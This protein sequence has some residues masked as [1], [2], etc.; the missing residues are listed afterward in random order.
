VHSAY[1]SLKILLTLDMDVFT[2][3]LSLY[4]YIVLLF[5]RVAFVIYHRFVNK[6]ML[7]HINVMCNAFI[8]H[9]CY[10]FCH[11][12]LWTHVLHVMDATLNWLY[13]LKDVVCCVAIMCSQNNEIYL[14]TKFSVHVLRFLHLYWAGSLLIYQ[15]ILLPVE[16]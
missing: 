4:F 14:D 8:F 2:I 1:P 7:F 11:I 12:L 6:L 10:V 5:R 16:C 9:I 13:H 3:A 15:R